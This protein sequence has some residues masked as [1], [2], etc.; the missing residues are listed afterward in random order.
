MAL[1]ALSLVGVGLC[2]RR[3][4]AP[5]AQPRAPVDVV[6][7]GLLAV[8]AAALLVLIQARTLR[9][10]APLVGAAALLA[11]LGALGL[12]RGVSGRRTG[13]VPR[14]FAG[15]PFYVDCAIGFGMFGGYF[16][17]LYAVPQILVHDHGWSVLAVGVA[18]LPGAILGAAAARAVGH[19]AASLGA[20]RLLAATAAAFTA[21]LG[22]A[23]ATGAAAGFVV[24][25]SFGFTAFGITQVA[26]VDR[27]SA[28]TP[29]AHRGAAAGLLNL[30]FLVGGS[31]GSSAAGA[32]S[33]SLG[34]PHAL[35][36][37]A[38]LPLAAGLIAASRLRHE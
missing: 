15:D 12:T 6:G 18:L 13:R 28:R 7:T 3:A 22:A 26:L 20:R 29:A 1:P 16:A 9:L 34:L 4:A 37:V 14:F 38:A 19:L 17:A 31:V 32:L 27:V 21:A 30:A 8:T 11:A 36:V 23:G 33:P 35:L 5:A 24:A 25:A 10:P 2:L